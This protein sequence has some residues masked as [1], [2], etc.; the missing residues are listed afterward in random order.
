MSFCYNHH[1]VLSRRIEQFWRNVPA[2][3]TK[4]KDQLNTSA[5]DRESSS[6]VRRQKIIKEEGSKEEDI[7]TELMYISF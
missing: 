4:H 5:F 3:T 1:I 6:G 2:Y 7:D